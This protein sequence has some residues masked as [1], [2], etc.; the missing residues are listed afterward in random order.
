MC[1]HNK[2]HKN[3][4]HEAGTVPDNSRHG[5]GIEIAFHQPFQEETMVIRCTLN[6]C[7]TLAL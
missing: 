6:I 1:M 4:K 3:H 5:Y 2:Q 7:S